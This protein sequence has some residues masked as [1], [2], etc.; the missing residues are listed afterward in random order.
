MLKLSLRGR[1][2]TTG[3]R[4]EA[5]A[6]IRTYRKWSRADAVRR[7]QEQGR[8]ADVP[9]I[10]IQMSV[11]KNRQM[12]Y[13]DQ[14]SNDKKMVSLDSLHADERRRVFVEGDAWR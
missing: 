7:A 12:I 3:Y 11:T 10:M 6:E 13:R 8:Y 9:G 14:H 2:G 1:G 4:A 5:L